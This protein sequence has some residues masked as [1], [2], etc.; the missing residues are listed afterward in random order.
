MPYDNAPIYAEFARQGFVE[1]CGV[2]GELIVEEFRTSDLQIVPFHRW[3]AATCPE[4]PIDAATLSAFRALPDR[5]AHLPSRL[6]ETH[7][8]EWRLAPA[9][10]VTTMLPGSG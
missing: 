6:R 3:R 10:S 7:L 1:E 9:E 4:A 2:I 8:R 5:K